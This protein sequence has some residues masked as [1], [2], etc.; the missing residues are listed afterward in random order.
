M[1]ITIL[2]FF[3]A[4]SFS[5]FSQLTIIPDSSFEKALIELGLDDERDGQVLSQNIHKVR[6]L[7]VAWKKITDLTGIQDF[8]S[9]EILHCDGNPITHLDL[10]RNLILKELKLDAEGDFT[11]K[12]ES[13]DLSKNIMLTNLDCGTSELK[14]LNL[15]KNIELEVLNCDFTAMTNLDLTKNVKLRFISC[16]YNNF[17]NI[18]FSH[19]IKLEEV[20][21]QGNKLKQLDLSNNPNLII[22]FVSNNKL[23]KILLHPSVKLKKI[24]TGDNK[25]DFEELVSQ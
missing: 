8:D 9:L 6:V 16:C 4:L 23:S 12:I 11:Y 17:K 1:R 3:I 19:N 7:M 2:S 14:H 5:V 24:A 10:S 18:D 13:L 20:Y 15:N 25:K 22:L 21:M